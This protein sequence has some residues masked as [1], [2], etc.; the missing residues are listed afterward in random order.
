V[1]PRTQV[2]HHGSRLSIVIA[3][4]DQTEREQRRH[5]IVAGNPARPVGGSNSL[6]CLRIE[7]DA[8]ASLDLGSDGY[9]FEL[10]GL[11]RS[12]LYEW[13]ARGR[14]PNR[15]TPDAPRVSLSEVERARSALDIAKQRG[16]S[17]NSDYQ[18]HKSEFARVQAERAQLELAQMLG[19]TV[20]RVDVEEAV[21][22]ATRELRNTLIRRWRILAVE[23]E[24]LTAREI[25]A[26]G[27]AADEAALAELVRKLT[28]DVVEYSLGQSRCCGTGEP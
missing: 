18:R 7:Q 22:A 28:L 3:H 2:F 13:V 27:L 23:L 16:G 19:L 1:S 24:G 15:G 4:L 26:R 5:C 14:V 10:Q 11:G 6:A 8:D 25:E 9:V 17:E 12:T 21:E 20:A